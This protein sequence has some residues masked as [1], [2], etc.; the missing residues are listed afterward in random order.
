MSDRQGFIAAICAQPDDDVARLV[1]ADWLEEHGEAERAAFIRVQCELA[2]IRP[3]ADPRRGADLATGRYYTP[4]LFP[5]WQELDRRERE[6]FK[7]NG[8]NQLEWMGK[9]LH[10]ICEPGSEWLAHLPWFRRGLVERIECGAE[11]FL[12]VAP[13]LVWHPEMTDVCEGCY[14]VEEHGA[15]GHANYKRSECPQCHGT[16]RIPR[17]CPA[18]AQP[19]ERVKLTTSPRI[20]VG[21]PGWVPGSVFLEAGGQRRVIRLPDD[22]KDALDE[23]D[24]PDVL[25]AEFPGIAFELP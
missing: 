12:R 16:G 17:P 3:E 25:K 4:P 9:A 22:F 7:A 19:I 24:I 6:L 10:D 20:G 18:T 1:Y 11:D 14:G 23:T 5:R 21:G 2:R 8:P 13:A 15:A